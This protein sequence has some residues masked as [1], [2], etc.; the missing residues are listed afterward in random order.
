MGEQLSLPGF[1]T[2][3]PTDQLFF[4]I[5]PDAAAAQ[6]IAR[7]ARQMGAKHGL[8]GRSLPVGRLHVSLHHLGG[9]VGVPPGVVARAGQAAGMVDLLPFEVGFDRAASFA[10]KA[11]SRPFVLRGGDGVA[12]LVA[13]R[14]ALG[15]A[16]AKAG[17]AR[18]AKRR[19]TPHLTMFYADRGIADQAVGPIGWTV[20]EFVLVHSLLGRTR[21]VPLGRWSLHG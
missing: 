6:H 4:G 18:P 21:Y 13:F 5:F 10:G 2:A 12:A 11:G 17:F 19:F 16:M 7:L 8:S 9:F 15:L 14:Q 1:H 20:R 3:G